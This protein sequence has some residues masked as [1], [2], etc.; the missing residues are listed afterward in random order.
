EVPSPAAGGIAVVD[1]TVYAGWG[2]WLT[3]PAEGADGGLIAFRLGGGGDGDD[4]AGE[5]AAGD[6]ADEVG[7]DVYQARCASCHGARG[8]GASGPPMVGV[9]ERLTRDEHL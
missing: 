4:P 6:G 9:A 8:E 2:W 1:G 5:A 3:G 7:R